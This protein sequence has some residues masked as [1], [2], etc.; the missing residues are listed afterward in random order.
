MVCG[1]G[2]LWLLLEDP[3]Q[4]TDLPLTPTSSAPPANQVTE[5]ADT[6]KPEVE[7]AGSQGFAQTAPLLSQRVPTKSPFPLEPSSLARHSLR[8]QSPGKKES[9]TERPRHSRG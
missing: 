9:L 5:E 6:K 8:A 4:A 1:A 2:S 7:L 3:R